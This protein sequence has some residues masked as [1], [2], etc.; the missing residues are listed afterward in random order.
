VEHYQ[1]SIAES[2]L[3]EYRNV[4]G[5]SADIHSNNPTRL[6]EDDSDEENKK[7]F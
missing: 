3:I 7:S 6:L 5:V 1:S 2:V 4:S